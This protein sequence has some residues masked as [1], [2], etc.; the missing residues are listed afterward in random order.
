MQ[1]NGLIALANF[2]ALRGAPRLPGSCPTP[3]SLLPTPYSLLP[4]PYTLHPTLNTLRSA[5]YTLHCAPYAL[6]P[7]SHTLILQ[8][9]SVGRR[10]EDVRHD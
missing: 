8:D 1:E 10:M 9:E 5:P 2:M 3:Y 6:H 7:T 4:T